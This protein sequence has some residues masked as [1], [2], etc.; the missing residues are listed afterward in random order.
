MRKFL[1][2]AKNKKSSL[3]DGVKIWENETDWILMI[4]DQYGNFLNIYMQAKD[5]ASGQ[6][7]HDRYTKQMDL[8]MKE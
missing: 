8:W 1:E 4:P 5:D 7:L 6:I 3:L 2:S